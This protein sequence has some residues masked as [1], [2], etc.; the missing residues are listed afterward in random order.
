[1]DLACLFE[2][3]LSRSNTPP[4][5]G[6]SPTPSVPTVHAVR[7]PWSRGGQ[8]PGQEGPPRATSAAPVAHT[9]GGHPLMCWSRCSGRCAATTRT[10]GRSIE[11][12]SGCTNAGHPP[13]LHAGTHVPARKGH[14]T[15]TRLSHAG[16]PTGARA[17]TR[18]WASHSD[19]A[20]SLEMGSSVGCRLVPDCATAWRHDRGTAATLA[21]SRAPVR[22]TFSIVLKQFHHL[23]IRQLTYDKRHDIVWA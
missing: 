2:A 6:L 20:R 12:P 9:S 4:S 5:S 17:R 15:G 23:Y 10:T 13:V 16:G 8:T 3:I 21:R 1:M 11:R 22:Q 7:C 18:P 14:R 19:L